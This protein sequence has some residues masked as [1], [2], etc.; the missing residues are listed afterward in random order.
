MCSN[1]DPS[2]ADP[3]P[4]SHNCIFC[5]F[6]NRLH[7]NFPFAAVFFLPFS[8]KEMSHSP[9][10]VHKQTKTTEKAP[11]GTTAAVAPPKA[12]TINIPQLLVVP[13]PSTP[14]PSPTKSS[15]KSPL[16]RRKSQNEQQKPERKVSFFHSLKY[17]YTPRE[18]ENSEHNCHEEWLSD[19]QREKETE[20]D[21]GQKK[22]KRKRKKERKGQPNDAKATE[23][24]RKKAATNGGTEGG[25]E[26]EDGTARECR[27]GETATETPLKPDSI[28]FARSQRRS[29]DSPRRRRQQ[30]KGSRRKCMGLF[31][32][33]S[34]RRLFIG[35]TASIRGGAKSQRIEGKAFVRRGALRQKNVHEVKLHKFIPRFFKQPTFCSHCK[36]FI[37]GLNKQG[38]Q[39]Q[40]CT[41]VVHKRCHEFVSFA[42]PGAD[43]GVDSDDP[44]QQHRWEATTY[45]SPTFCDHCGSLLYGLIHQ[46]MKCQCCYTSVHHRCVKYV[47]N[48]CGMDHTEKRGRIDLGTFIQDGVLHIHIREARN[49]IPMDPNGL[50]DPYVKLKLI[51]FEDEQGK[52]KQKTRTIKATLNPIWDEHFQFK[53]EPSDKDRRLSVEVWDWDRTSRNDFM[54]SLSFGISELIKEPMDGWFKLLNDEEGEYYNIPI[55]PEDEKDIEQLQKKM[56][57]LHGQRKGA[58]GEEG[59]AKSVTKQRQSA[60]TLENR[61]QRHKEV[62]KAADF[63]FITVLGKGS[64]GKVLLGEHKHLKELFAIKILK[65][66]VI[67]QDDDVECTM[68]EK[69]VL[70][71]PD[72][73]PFLVALH[74]CFQTMDRLYFVMEFV[75]GGDL[76][77]Q[78]QQVGKFKEPVAVFYSAEIAC[79]LFYLHSKGIIYRD[80]KL[81]NVMLERDGHIKITDFG[82][83][84]EGIQGD[85]TTKTFCGTPDYIAP[86]II[87]YQPYGKSVDWW[88]YGVLLF[89][90]LAG[91]PPFDG[92]DED[93]LFTAITEHN[94]SYP[95]SMSKESV[96][97]CK[98]FLSKAP[99]K[100]LGCSAD[101]ERQIKEHCFFR[102]IDWH[103]IETR[104]V[105]PPF[106]P[107]ISNKFTTDNF[108]PLFLRLPLKLTPP[109]WDILE[110]MK[111]DEF[112]LFDHF[113]SQYFAEAASAESGAYAEETLQRDCSRNGDDAISL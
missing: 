23:G 17:H 13:S 102:R 97:I 96:L 100:R 37:W 36:D 53:L 54:G 18:D 40:V 16:T 112:I 61:V 4:Q 29:G 83:C 81:D 91:Q 28:V 63:N 38:F 20:E 104:Q 1:F 55:P 98:G 57:D 64:F 113:N 32:I 107:K 14:P 5:P 66:D 41:L 25:T 8:V 34:F 19:E 74:S 73:P 6:R 39:C 79:G 67:I 46:G 33:N 92:E 21:D 59:R 9:P 2:S 99:S 68:V 15:L 84:K 35:A 85:T 22:Q 77:Y 72:K 52:A 76:M 106:K 44:R 90:M 12:T 31:G 87:L 30:Q 108:D 93:E 42:C 105:Q 80:L 82:M 86:E 56:A 69:R 45:S 75:N 3:F 71:L 51:P 95:K 47:P 10:S 7:V 110:G 43:K 88:A 109:E 48:M 101:G 70:A 11:E 103:K 24:R 58:L 49:L 50:S 62:V 65:K 26:A 60:T 94:V 111:G 89:E 78:I 27:E